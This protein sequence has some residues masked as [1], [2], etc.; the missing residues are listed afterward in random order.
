[1]Y[2]EQLEALIKNVLADGVITD[3]E[4]AVL[5]KKAEAEGIDV[6]EIDVYIEG[7]LDKIRNE[8]MKAKAQVRKCPACGEIIPALSNI[9]PSCGAA[10]DNQR[11]DDLH[12]LLVRI[13]N[14]LVDIKAISESSFNKKSEK[15]YKEKKAIFEK[16]V[17]E[18]RVYYGENKRVQKLIAELQQELTTVNQLNKKYKRNKLFTKIVSIPIVLLIIYAVF[19]WLVIPAWEGLDSESQLLLILSGVIFGILGILIW[20]GFASQSKEEIKKLEL[21]H[22]RE[23]KKIELDEKK[24]NKK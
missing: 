22:E 19:K 18:A 20:R 14:D 6:D 4:R 5:H 24:S 12:K 10:V 3:K 21:E 8:Q 16:D 17:R 1:M 15:E 23:M 11:E 2:S 13:E 9:C 7:E